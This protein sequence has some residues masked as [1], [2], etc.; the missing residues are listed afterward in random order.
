M[1]FKVSVDI[2]FPSQD[3]IPRY[4]T[5]RCWFHFIHMYITHIS[6]IF[7][8][9]KMVCTVHQT[10]KPSHVKVQRDEQDESLKK[11]EDDFKKE[12]RAELSVQSSFGSESI[13]D[14]PASQISLRSVELIV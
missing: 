9:S 10:T 12:E 3:T 5:A 6:Y 1:I 7:F 8:H 13:P 2:E 4:N 14:S 11:C